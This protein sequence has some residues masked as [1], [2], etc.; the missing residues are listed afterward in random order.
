VRH[1]TRR[2]PRTDGVT[3]IVVC[4]AD[5]YEPGWGR[6]GIERERERV[7]EWTRRWPELA[8]RHR[9]ARGRQPQHTFFYPQEEYREEHLDR[10]A[11]ICRTGCGDVEVHLHHDRDTSADLRVKLET[12]ARTLHERHGLLRMG[13]SGRPEYAFIHGNWALDN[14]AP[15]GRNCGVND[16]LRVLRETGCYADFTFPSAPDGS[17]PPIINSIYYATDDPSQPASHFRGVPVEAGRP[18]SGDLMLV[19][20]PLTLNWRSRKF[21]LMPRIENGELSGDAPPTPERIDLWVQQ[22][23]HVVGRPD[24]VFIKL[25][26]HGAQEKNF[27]ANLGAPRREMHEYLDRVYNDGRRYRL[28]YASAREMYDLI[29]AAESQTLPRS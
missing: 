28:L 4:V 14:S 12:F 20:G 13:A 29:K 2:R 7:M 23:V 5:H 8:A 15:S 16:E 27:E 26:T 19:Q 10:L 17:Q 18:P 9:D 1:V 3:T 24:Y 21:G 6:P 22:H 11:E 25:H